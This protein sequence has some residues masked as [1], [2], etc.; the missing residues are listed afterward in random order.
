MIC[1]TLP[2]FFLDEGKI[3]LLSSGRRAAC[4][5]HASLVTVG[6]LQLGL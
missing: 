3:L 5:L 4:V 1:T 6:G 2:V